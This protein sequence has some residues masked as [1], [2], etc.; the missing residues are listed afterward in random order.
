MTATV[1]DLFCGAGGS[2]IGLVGAGLELK[3]AA[4]HW[5]RAINVHMTTLD[6][7]AH[8]RPITNLAPRKKIIE[9]FRAG[10][11]RDRYGNGEK[12]IWLPFS[13]FR[14]SLLIGVPLRRID[15]ARAVVSVLPIHRATSS[16]P[17]VEFH[18]TG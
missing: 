5:Q 11:R 4:N 15:H 14:C 13:L 16:R 9:R 12:A 1:C 17:V 8:R 2:S 7:P 10:H 6:Q 3:L 18:N